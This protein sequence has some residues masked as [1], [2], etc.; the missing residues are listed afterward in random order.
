MADVLG[1]P[2]LLKYICDWLPVRPHGLRARAV[3]RAWRLATTRSLDADE[4]GERV[5]KTHERM[6]QYLE[7]MRGK[8]NEPLRHYL[9]NE[10]Y[11]ADRAL[12]WDGAGLPRRTGPT[13]CPETGVDCGAQTLVEH[14]APSV[15][16]LLAMYENGDIPAALLTTPHPED[17]VRDYLLYMCMQHRSGAALIVSPPE[18]VSAWAEAASNFEPSLISAQTYVRGPA[19]REIFPK[20]PHWRGERRWR[21]VISTYDTVA[22]MMKQV[23]FKAWPWKTVF[24]VGDPA[25]ALKPAVFTGEAFGDDMTG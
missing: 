2:D 16:W 18:N 17:T 12:L 25:L 23:S 7:F 1:D 19:K 11:P 24:F 4:M 14:L 6:R 13:M 10:P 3:A 20:A 21:V 5:A 9:T 15:N 8:I 22:K